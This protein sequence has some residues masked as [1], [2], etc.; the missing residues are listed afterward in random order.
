MMPTGLVMMS[1]L[2]QTLGLDFAAD[3]TL[4]D[5]ACTAWRFSTGAPSIAV[6]GRCRLRAIMRC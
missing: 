6:S 1:E 5:S 3:D 2:P 4:A